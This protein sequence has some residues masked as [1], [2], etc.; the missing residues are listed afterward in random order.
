MSRTGFVTRCAAFGLATLCSC[1]HQPLEPDAHQ[2]R[3]VVHDAHRREASAASVSLA[4]AFGTPPALAATA[5]AGTDLR[6]EV[7]QVLSAKVSSIA[8]GEGSRIAVLSEPPQ[9]G[10]DRGLR[11]LPLPAALRAK[12]GDVDDARIYFGRDNEP[13]IMG[14]RHSGNVESP[15]YWRHTAAAGW[16][17]GREEIG[18]LGG[19]AHRGLWGVL[20]SA[21]PEL[22]CRAG[23][24][25]IIKRTSG[26]TTAPA[27]GAPRTVV[28]QDG[29]LWALDSSGISGIDAHGWALAIPAPA[30]SAPR[31]FWATRGAAWVSTERE[32]FRFQEGAWS[33]LPLPFKDVTSWWG[34]TA[35][36]VWLVGNGGIA[37]FDG[38]RFRTSAVPGQLRVIV[39]RPNGEIWFGGDAG[40]F[41]PATNPIAD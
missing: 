4:A 21:D 38:Q 22:V 41:R 30:G 28:L 17:D 15:I 37:R 16:R 19:P 10:D 1:R 31:S 33:T 35:D 3:P 7:V 34:R 40:L 9:V 18:Q 12:P 36:S 14:T 39:G 27:G 13:R 29:V 20:G 5:A 8:L 11:A 2:A 24:Q 6:L 25:C 32:L 23:A 26:W